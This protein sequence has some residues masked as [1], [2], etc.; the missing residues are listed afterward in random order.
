LP[1]KE[2]TKPEI[3]EKVLREN[4]TKKDIEIAGAIK[5]AYP[6]VFKDTQTETIRKQVGAMR[7]SVDLPETKKAP[8]KPITVAEVIEEDRIVRNLK[9]SAGDYKLKYEHL[10][11]QDEKK[12]QLIDL[13]TK[14]AEII[15][16]EPVVENPSIKKSQATVLTLLSDIHIEHRIDK[17]SVN[18]LNE[19]NPDIARRRIHSYFTNLMKLIRKERQDVVIE[20]VVVGLLGDNIHGFIHE[21][22]QQTNYM[23]PIEASLFAYEQLLAGFNY[24]LEN[25]D[26]IK[27]FTII[28]KVGNHSRT[29]EKSYTD[30]E[31]VMSF[32][33]GLYKH[34]AKHFENEKRI[35]FIIEENYFTYFDIY[36]KTIRFH[37]GHAFRYCGGI[38]GLYIPLLKF[39]LRAN[40][41]R[42]AHVDAIGH[43]HS[44]IHI[45]QAMVNGC[46]CGLNAY[47]SKLGFQP[48]PPTQQFQLIDSKRGFTLNLPILLESN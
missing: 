16:V 28:C 27:N 2:L 14:L 21:E 48:E 30:A 18:W 42:F 20:N 31:A 9:K 38:G 22:Y 32:E 12:S 36:N 45:P 23:T 41:Q 19:Y 7:H 4:Y 35:K 15:D 29:T 44:H 24:M 3:L 40:Q 25:D 46:I 43:W 34:L 26:K 1:K 5:K 6:D 11:K 13:H 33:Y 39:V 10:L 17:V 8:E 47:A 37:H